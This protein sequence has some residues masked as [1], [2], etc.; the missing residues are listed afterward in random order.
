MSQI[1]NVDRFAGKFLII[2]DLLSDMLSLDKKRHLSVCSALLCHLKSQLLL[3]P[4]G[5]SPASTC[6]FSLC[7]P[8]Q[9]FTLLAFIKAGMEGVGGEESNQRLL[10][11]KRGNGF[12]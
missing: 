3:C 8:S 4:F 7:A 5:H 6:S 12:I 9:T 2:C 10:G 1:V 11:H